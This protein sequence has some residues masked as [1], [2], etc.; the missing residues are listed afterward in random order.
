M[1][2]TKALILLFSFSSRDDDDEDEDD[3]DED[4]EEDDDDDADDDA[5]DDG[6]VD[7]DVLKAFI[8]PSSARVNIA[9]RCG[10]LLGY[11]YERL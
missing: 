8:N 4:D 1:R 3:E 9:T 11:S 6:N 5:E 2:G 10:D 7:E